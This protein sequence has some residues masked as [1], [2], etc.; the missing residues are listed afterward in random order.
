MRWNLRNLLAMFAMFGGIGMM[1]QGAAIAQCGPHNTGVT[2]PEYPCTLYLSN[3]GG[4]MF[5]AGIVVEIVGLIFY[6]RFPPAKKS[7]SDKEYRLEPMKIDDNDSQKN[8]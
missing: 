7:D 6:R 8:E 3:V 1:A 2:G 5:Y 4:Q